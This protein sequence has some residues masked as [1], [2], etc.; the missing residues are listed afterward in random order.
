MARLH[1]GE[2]SSEVCALIVDAWE[3]RAD[4][5]YIAAK[6]RAAGDP[7]LART[8]A[9]LLAAARQA[10]RDAWALAALESAARPRPTDNRNPWDHPTKET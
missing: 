6:A 2:L 1:G 4:A 8:A 5:R 7:D 10:Q 9:Q 3:S